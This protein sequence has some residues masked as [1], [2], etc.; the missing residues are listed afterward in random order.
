MFDHVKIGVSD[1]AVSKAFF[2]KVLEPLGV[3]IVA[4]GEPAY[5]FV[6]DPDGHNIEAVYH[7][8]ETD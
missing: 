3:A 8:E 5:G 1:Y 7:D 4:G 6:I 2:Q